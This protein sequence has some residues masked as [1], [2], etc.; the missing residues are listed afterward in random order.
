MMGLVCERPGKLSLV[1]T[2]DPVCGPED[3]LI[4]IRRVGVCGTDYHIYKGDQPYLTYPRLIGHELAG[5]IVQAPASS[6]FAPGDI[7]AVE[8]YLYCGECIA[9]RKGRTNCCQ[10]ISVLGVH[11]DGGMCAYLTV[12]PRNVV[13][14]AGLSLDQAAMLE[15]LSIGAHG[16]RRSQAAAGDRVLV[17][18]AGPIGIAAT[19]F[20]Q[21]RGAQVTV[22]ERNENRLK[23]CEEILN[24]AHGVPA[25]NGARDML[26]ELTAG[27]FY[28]IVIDATGSPG[29]MEK[30][31]GFVAHGGKYVLLSIVQA[32]IAFHDPDFHKREMTLLSSRN[33]TKEDFSTVVDAIRAGKVPTGELATHRA[34]LAAAAGI[35]PRWAQPDSGVI[36]ALIEV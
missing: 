35:I 8:P 10:Q 17:V 25:G 22:L 3:V 33:A 13:S 31:F 4:R 11:Q 36:K 9:C 1:E 15:F 26:S 19:I 28:D 29:A 30:G 18:G 32:D 2:D 24:V 20:A 16:I 27:A 14:A 34:P 7:V 5:E 21:A 6:R 12:P 23:F